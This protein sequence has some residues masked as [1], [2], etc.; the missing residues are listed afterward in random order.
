MRHGCRWKEWKRYRPELRDAEDD[1][2]A[3]CERER[4]HLTRVARGVDDARLAEARV[5]AAREELEQD[6]DGVA[7]CKF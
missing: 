5:A 2:L 4:S 6:E 3:G 1:A 7:E